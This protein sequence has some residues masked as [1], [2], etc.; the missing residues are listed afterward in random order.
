LGCF[1][2]LEDDAE[3]KMGNRVSAG[4]TLIYGGGTGVQPVLREGLE[5]R[6][7]LHCAVEKTIRANS[8]LKVKDGIST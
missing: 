3:G 2:L 6:H 5:V 4:S 8:W 7:E 1:R